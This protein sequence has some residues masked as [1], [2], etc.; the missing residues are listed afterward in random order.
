M[1]VVI[2]LFYVRHDIYFFLVKNAF[3]T[4]RS[5]ILLIGKHQKRS[6]QDAAI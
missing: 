4:E 3:I 6:Y 1:M 5:G 2:F